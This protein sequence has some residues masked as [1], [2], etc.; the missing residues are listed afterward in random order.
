MD[1]FFMIT[2]NIIFNYSRRYFNEM[3]FKM[4]VLKGN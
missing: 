3:N 2:R 1:F 4:T